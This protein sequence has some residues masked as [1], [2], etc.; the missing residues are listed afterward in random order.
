MDHAA[1]PS[2]FLFGR[3]DA[4]VLKRKLRILVFFQ[5]VKISKTKTAA[6][7]SRLHG[8]TVADRSRKR[9]C[10]PD[11]TSIRAGVRTTLLAIA[12]LGPSACAGMDG[13]AQV[14]HTTY[15]VEKMGHGAYSVR[16]RIIN[17]IGDAN[18]AKTDNVQAAAK[19]CAKKGLAVTAISDKGGGGL[20]L[21]NTLTFRCGRAGAT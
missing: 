5:V 14:G 11:A 9:P 2:S 8:L 13:I 10:V 19:Y 4:G 7:L 15:N 20:A 18:D 3:K 21:E 6:P 17:P 1:T 12:A 16:T